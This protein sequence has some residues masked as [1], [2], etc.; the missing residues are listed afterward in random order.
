MMTFEPIIRNSIGLLCRP[1]RQ[2]IFQSRNFGIVRTLNPWI[3]GLK[4]RLVSWDCNP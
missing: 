1:K 2:P 4:M 3:S